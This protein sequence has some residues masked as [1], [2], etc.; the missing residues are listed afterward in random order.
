MADWKVLT[1]RDK[2]KIVR[3]VVLG[4]GA[5]A[6]VYKGLDVQACRNVAVKLYKHTETDGSPRRSALE[7]FRKSVTVLKRLC[8]IDDDEERQAMR[9][10]TTFSYD[11]GTLSHCIAVTWRRSNTSVAS[12]ESATIA[13]PILD[14]VDTSNCY[15]RLLDY[16]CTETGEPGLDEHEKL[17]YLVLELGEESLEERL[18]RHRTRGESLS[19]KELRELQWA[20]VCI[21]WGLHA[22]GFVHMD[23]KPQ[24]IMRFRENGAD[25][26]KLIDL[27]GAMETGREIRPEQVTFT[28]EYMPPELAKAWVAWTSG[29]PS[30]RLTM[31]RLM[32]VWSIGMCSLEAIFLQ[33]V[34]RP[35]FEEWKKETGSEEKFFKWLADYDTEPILH[36]DMHEM[37][38]GMD[39]DMCDLLETMLAKDPDTRS[40]INECLT[41]P[42]FSSVHRALIGDLKAG[43]ASGHLSQTEAWHSPEA[44]VEKK[45]GPKSKLCT[46]M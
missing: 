17:L 34:L 37:L 12:A 7:E 8:S 16:S 35:W 28:P 43:A 32:D 41:H 15:V 14:E 40:S 31:S 36:G 20:L 24:N 27:D 11:A 4:E 9:R 30:Y 26:W 10:L 42:W 5:S 3:K 45:I 22:V 38:A 21:V 29:D 19:V 39:K 2:Y 44:A 18:Q 33:P 23:I 1:L 6:V 46:V 13:N 25:H